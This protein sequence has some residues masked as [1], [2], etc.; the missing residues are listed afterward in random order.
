M[1]QRVRH[2]DIARQRLELHHGLPAD[3]VPLLVLANDVGSGIVVSDVLHLA[4]RYRAIVVVLTDVVV[5]G[6]R[7]AGVRGL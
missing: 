4:E 2:P 6:L 5:D 7:E 3:S 1:L